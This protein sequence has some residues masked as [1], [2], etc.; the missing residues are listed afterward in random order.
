MYLQKKCLLAENST[1]SATTVLQ[2][3]NFCVVSLSSRIILLHNMLAGYVLHTSETT[4]LQAGNYCPS[5]SV[6]NELPRNVLIILMSLHLV[7]F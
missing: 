6:F 1:H 7:C 4:A 2:N 5:I 3:M